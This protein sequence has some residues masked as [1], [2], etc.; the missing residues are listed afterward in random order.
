MRGTVALCLVFAST[1]MAQEYTRGIGIYPGDPKEY[2]GP[3][4]RVDMSSYRNIALHRPA[5][6]SSSYDYN[7]T[8][9]LITDGIKE[10][11]LP[12]WVSTSSSERGTFKKNEREWLLDHNWVTSVPLSGKTGWVQVSL[13]GGDVLPEV[14]RVDVVANVRSGFEQGWTAVVSGSDDG[15]AWTELG[16]ISGTDRPPGAFRKTIAWERPVRNRNYR[17][18]LH[19]PRR[20]DGR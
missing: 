3:T 18:E 6:H 12:L 15:Q 13:G 8:A 11:K 5:Y 17:V 1:V 9:Q 4:V 7:L 10:S 20:R 16:R 19:R 14:N 2:F